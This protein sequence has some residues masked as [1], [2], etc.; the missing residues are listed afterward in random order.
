MIDERIG[1]CIAQLRKEKGIT[2]EALARAIG[3]SA[4][5]V[6][7]WESGGSPDIALLPRI[8]DY[9]AVSIDRLFGREAEM[10]ADIEMAVVRHVAKGLDAQEKDAWEAPQEVMAE[11]FKQGERVCWAAMMGLIGTKLYDDVG[12]SVQ[13]IFEGILDRT[14]SGNVVVNGHIL[15]DV[16]MVL[17][18]AHEALP[19]FFYLPDVGTGWEAGL[20][21]PDAYAKLFA[22][23]GSGDVMQSLFLLHR[24]DPGTNFTL[25]YL[26]KEAVLDA[27]RATRVI[28]AL[29]D[30]KFVK[31]AHIE[32]DEGRQTFYEFKPNDAFIALLA[33]AKPVI[34]PPKHFVF[35]GEKRD[36]PLLRAVSEP[37]EAGAPPIQT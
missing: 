29:I 20:L 6:S 21:S 18:S 26:M 34:E 7:K 17:A 23:L 32:L 35:Q 31:A 5:A 11:A 10:V 13:T 25:G 37:M 30:M 4:Q 2:Q 9:F 15:L 36:K 22:A 14:K 1:D 27:E 19:Y 24:K 16:G 3:V 12:M 28:D 8:A 33:M